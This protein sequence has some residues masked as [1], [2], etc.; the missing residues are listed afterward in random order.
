M[1]GGPSGIRGGLGPANPVGHA[2][3]AFNVASSLG[4]MG[5]PSGNSLG[6]SSQMSPAGPGGMASPAS[7][8]MGNPNDAGNAA[9]YRGF[10]SNLAGAGGAM[11]HPSYNPFSQG[12]QFG[13]GGPNGSQP[14]GIGMFGNNAASGQNGSERT[15]GQNQAAMAALAPRQ[16]VGFAS[17]SG[18]IPEAATVGAGFGRPQQGLGQRPNFMI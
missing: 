17:Q 14:G 8:S 11:T 2:G 16:R 6:A 9:A 3:G 18:N 5:S 13:G 10:T 12:N 1:L 7:P 15:F 4:G